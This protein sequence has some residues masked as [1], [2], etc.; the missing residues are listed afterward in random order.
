MS[1]NEGPIKVLLVDDHTLFR[2]GIAEIFATEED[3]R[4]VG[5]AGD[6]EE[7]AGLAEERK[8]HVVLLDV[9]MPGPGAEETLRRIL[10]VSPSPKVIVLTMYDEPRLVRNLLALGAR[11][12]MTKAAAREELLSAIRTVYRDNDRVILSVTRDTLERL[13]GRARSVL[14]SRELEILALM[15]RGMSNGQIASQLYISVGTVKRHATNIYAKLG[16]CCRVD[17]INEAVATGLI[18]SGKFSDPNW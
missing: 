4:L 11:A 8:P 1:T 17:A 18:T 10:R 15:A 13:E 9:E 7:A 2:E 14:S 5:E 3:M 16:V 12:Y 6:G